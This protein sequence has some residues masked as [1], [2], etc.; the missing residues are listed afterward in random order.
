MR[1]LKLLSF[2]SNLIGLFA[3]VYIIY[4]SK[5]PFLLVLYLLY[6]A[7]A[8]LIYKKHERVFFYLSLNTSLLFLIF[9]T[10][11]YIEQTGLPF[12]PGGDAFN[13]YEVVRNMCEGDFSGYYGRYKLYLFTVWKYYEIIEFFTN[14]STNYIYFF[15]LNIFI[16]CNISPLLYKI[17][18]RMFDAKVVLF[19]CVLTSLFPPLIQVATNTWREG[20]VYAPFLYSIYLSLNI[21]KNINILLYLI[22]FLFVVNIRAEIGIA[23]LVFFILY[24]FI[25]V[26]KG[27]KKISL[28]QKG[29]YFSIFLFMILLF[30]N[31][32]LFEYFNYSNASSLEY[33]YNAYNDMSNE[34]SGNNSISNKLR[35]GGLVGRVLLFFYTPF[36]PIPP[37]VFAT[38]TFDFYSFFISIGAI[39]WYFIFP[40]SVISIKNGLNDLNL[41]RFSKS[42]LITFIIGIIIIS[43]TAVGSFR[44]KLYLY[45]IFFVYFFN[46][47]Y[48]QKREKVKKIFFGIIFTYLFALLIYLYFKNI[49]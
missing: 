12:A 30:Y 22:V 33:Q 41:S 24:N 46:Y 9:L 38:K 42:Y 17:S 37:P 48:M 26:D 8:F 34:F 13:Y 2:L 27:K 11:S 18:T 36:V 15:F 28:L 1:S 4:D 35:N 14:T 44:H 16:C 31:M 19:A 7:F 47:I 40:I 29:M 49:L 20:F 3:L 5:E 23:S 21:K 25:F 32:G 6:I 39:I 45:P 43:L 10:N